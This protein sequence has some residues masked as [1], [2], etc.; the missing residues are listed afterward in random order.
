MGVARPCLVSAN[1]KTTESVLDQSYGLV[2][3][4]LDKA[5]GLTEAWRSPPRRV[6]W[7]LGVMIGCM[8]ATPLAMA[9]AMNP[10]PGT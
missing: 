9:P 4:K 8:V 3:I 7:G 2:N 10:G 6:R 5:G 1:G